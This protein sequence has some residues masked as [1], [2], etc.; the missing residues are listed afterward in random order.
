MLITRGAVTPATMTRRV[1]LQHGRVSYKRSVCI[2]NIAVECI[3]VA[4][5]LGHGADRWTDEQ[6]DRRIA[7]SLYP[8][9]SIGWRIMTAI[10]FA[11]GK[12][13]S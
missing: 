6:T 10:D 5:S 9:Y 2:V 1:Q 13:P 12:I 4:M 11:T 8:P 3:T 7:A